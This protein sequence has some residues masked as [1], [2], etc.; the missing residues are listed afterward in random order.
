MRDSTS[1]RNPFKCQHAGALATFGETIG[2]L[3]VFSALKP[4][5]RCILTALEA[6]Y[7]RKARG[8]ITGTA[9]FKRPDDLKPG[10]NTVP[11]EIVLKDF[12]LETV[13]IVS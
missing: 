2:G 11:I 12:L 6:K 9:S 10:Q 4:K 3:A 7:V 5:D 1:T 13:A 8:P